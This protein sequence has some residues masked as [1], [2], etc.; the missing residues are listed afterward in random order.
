VTDDGRRVG[1]IRR[2]H[3]GRATVRRA[4]DEGLAESLLELL[5]RRDDGDDEIRDGHVDRVENDRIYLHRP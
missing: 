3:D 4:D 1:T 5:G 2:V